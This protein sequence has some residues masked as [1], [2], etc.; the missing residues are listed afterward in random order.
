M[1]IWWIHVLKHFKRRLPGN[2]I[3]VSIYSELEISLAAVVLLLASN[4]YDG[5][6]ILLLRQSNM[7]LRLVHDNVLSVF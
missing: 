5:C 6:V 2:W 4:C 7:I 3:K 1:V